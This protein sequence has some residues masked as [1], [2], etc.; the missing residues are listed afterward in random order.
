MQVPSLLNARA[1]RA[2]PQQH[3]R[4][5]ARRHRPLGSRRAGAGSRNRLLLPQAGSSSAAN[6]Q[7]YRHS[8]ARNAL[9]IAERDLAVPVSR[10]TTYL[11]RSNRRKMTLATHSFEARLNVIDTR[12]FR[13]S[14]CLVVLCA[15]APTWGADAPVSGRMV[16]LSLEDQ[17]SVLEDLFLSRSGP[18]TFARAFDDGLNPDLYIDLADFRERRA[19]AEARWAL[20][21]LAR[22]DAAQTLDL[23]LYRFSLDGLDEHPLSRLNLRSITADSP[24]F[25]LTAPPR[26]FPPEPWLL[27]TPPASAAVPPGFPGARH[28]AVPNECVEWLRRYQPRHVDPSPRMPTAVTPVVTDPTFVPALYLAVADGNPSIVRVFLDAGA[29]VNL[30]VLDSLRGGILHLLIRDSNRPPLRPEHAESI[31]LLLSHGLDIRKTDAGGQTVV[32]LA[33]STPL[34]N[35]LRS[36]LTQSLTTLNLV[37]RAVHR[38]DLKQINE[39]I[40]DRANLEER[41]AIGR[42]PLSVALQLGE[43][44]IA[45]ALLHGGAHIGLERAHPLSQVMSSSSGTNGSH[46]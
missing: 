30:D 33:K 38:R 40:N 22:R 43:P 32:D 34:A 37:H 1:C 29:N 5:A 16:T 35:S 20:Q 19:Q 14:L 31:S 10:G 44:A 42:T 3:R 45:R 46:T 17:R 36:A 11:K 12:Y 2:I 8:A 26:R 13:L 25:Y 28:R 6:A 7:C 4:S 41:D 15:L 21:F 24:C 9:V 39:L 23:P 27:G 18:D